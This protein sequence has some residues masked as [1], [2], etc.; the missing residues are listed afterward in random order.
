MYGSL[1]AANIYRFSSKDWNGNAGL[2]YYLYRF[3]DPNL[4][5]WLN[6]DP[7]QERG[8]INLY[9]YVYNNPV[10]RIDPNGLIGIGLVGGG[11]ATLGIGVGPT[12]GAS[13]GAGIFIGPN[14][15]GAEGSFGGYVSGGMSEPADLS[16]G[17]GAGIG[18][19]LFLTD[20]NNANDLE[21]TCKTAFINI[22]FGLD[23]SLSFSWGNGVHI[24]EITGGP[25]GGL[26][27]GIIPTTTVAGTLHPGGYVPP[28]P[29]IP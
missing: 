19:G 29:P 28:Q 8:G 20:A 17:A 21:K 4:Q 5:R 14:S 11:S 7:I 22:G 12:L 10:N 15:N 27:L 3:Y 16:I 24:L 2:Y 23:I 25:G 13:A 6:Q 18:P 1:A 9:D 26:S